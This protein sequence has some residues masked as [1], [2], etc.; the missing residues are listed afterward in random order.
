MAK[1]R[2]DVC[3][4]APAL[5]VSVTIE[6]RDDGSDD[7]HIHPGGQGFWIARMVRHLGAKPI[8]CA[9]LGGE[10]G[11]II[12]ALTAQWGIDLATAGI[13]AASPAYVHDRRKGDRETIA[14]SPAPV[15]DRHERDDVYS[16]VLD[17]ARP[18]IT[19]T[20]AGLPG[21]GTHRCAQGE[22]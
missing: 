16:A 20:P 9:P 4:F 12:E 1:K 2:H 13:A 18:V 19:A 8:L 5:F 14:A 7:I 22:R 15:L 3:V 6:E 11:T 10:T 17:H 21:R